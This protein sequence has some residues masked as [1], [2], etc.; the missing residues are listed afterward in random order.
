L[1]TARGIQHLHEQNIVHRDI[2]ARNMLLT[3]TGQ[4]KVS[5]FGLSRNTLEDGFKTKSKTG[6]LRWMAIESL[7]SREYSPQSD[8]WSYGVLMW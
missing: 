8:I 6:P 4:I 3:H 5:D 1:D 7:V 2:A